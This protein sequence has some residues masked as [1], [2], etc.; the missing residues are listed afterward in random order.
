MKF[1][2]TT[3]FRQINILMLCYA[4]APMLALLPL[5]GLID[6][7]FHRI[8]SS[9]TGFY[10]NTC[11]IPRNK[12]SWSSQRDYTVPPTLPPI[13]SKENEKAYFLSRRPVFRDAFSGFY[14]RQMKFLHCEGL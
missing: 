4:V 5:S 1:L 9:S 2:S 6:Q 7:V 14:E 3:I 10:L 12:K 13:S 8:L 11:A